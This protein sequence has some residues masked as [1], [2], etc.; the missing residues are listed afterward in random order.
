MDGMPRILLISA[1]SQPAT[2]WPDWLDCAIE[3]AETLTASRRARAARRALLPHRIGTHCL[4]MGVAAVALVALA[5]VGCGAGAAKTRSWQQWPAVNGWA[6]GK[7]SAR[8]RHRMAATDNETV[9]MLG[10]T[11]PDGQV[12][13]SFFKLDIQT[14]QWTRMTTTGPSTRIYHAMAATGRSVWIHGGSD[15]TIV[16]EVNQDS[17]TVR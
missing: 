7:P 4:R 3:T 8:R 2:I 10:G 11:T 15:G 16:S 13:E 12:S 1:K 14:R 5:S 9:W 17:G 6:I